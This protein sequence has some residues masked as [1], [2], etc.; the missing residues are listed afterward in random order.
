MEEQDHSQTEYLKK[1]PEYDLMANLAE[2]RAKLPKSHR[3]LN[4]LIE[5]PEYESDLD[6]ELLAKYSKSS[7]VILQDILRVYRVERYELQSKINHLMS[8]I[9][10]NKPQ[11]DLGKRCRRLD[12]QIEKAFH[13]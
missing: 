6:Y 1:R 2:K 3:E 12:V 13:V 5:L 9:R 7:N 11:L 8:I 10:N 4:H